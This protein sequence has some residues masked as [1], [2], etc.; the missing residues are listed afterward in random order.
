MVKD[1]FVYV[2]SICLIFVVLVAVGFAI[3]GIQALYNRTVGSDVSSSQT[4]MFHQSKGYV[5]GMTQD[6]SKNKLELSQTTDPVA[7][8]AIIAHII[9][10]FANFDETKIK[11]FDLRQF[12][13][14]VRNGNIK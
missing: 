7:R 14:D 2:I 3:G 1:T 4:D 13:I 6:L 8:G 5:D 11:N 12:L 9:E 10:E